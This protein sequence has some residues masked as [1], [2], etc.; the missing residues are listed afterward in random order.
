MCF[1]GA[2]QQEQQIS[3]SQ[4][5]MMQTLQNNYNTQFAGQSAILNN[6]NTSASSILSQGIGQKGF[7]PAEE[8]A[9]RTQAS[10]GTAGA[11]KMAK[12]ATG[13]SLAAL[14]GGNVFLPSGTAAGISAN[15]AQSAAAQNAAQ[16][17]GITESSYAQGRQNYLQAANILGG[18]AGQMQPLGY[19]GAATTAG[20]QAFGSASQIQQQNQAGQKAL[21]G[22]LGGGLEAGLSFIPGAGG[23]I[24]SN[25]LGGA[26]G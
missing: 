21:M 14:G 15:L 9:M 24:A 25:I 7:T 2:S 20:G 1:G 19:A 16:Q 4:Q 17:L 13:E 23:D 10:E 8:A 26:R 6:L 11:Y 3:Q 5:Q 12:A 18:V 22:M